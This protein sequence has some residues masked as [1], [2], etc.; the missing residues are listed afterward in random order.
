MSFPVEV[1]A[2]KIYRGDD[3]CQSFRLV[4]NSVPTDL[5]GFDSW[6]AEWRPYTDSLESIS[7]TVEVFLGDARV[8]ICASS[9]DTLLMARAG[10]WDVQATDSLNGDV[11][12]FFFGSTTFDKDVT[13]V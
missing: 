4:T 11:R 9:A 3:F 7:L 5:S 2:L 10:V 12:T 8:T 1:P 6:V 13:Y